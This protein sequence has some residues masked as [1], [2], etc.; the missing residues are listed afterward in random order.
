MEMKKR[1]CC[2]LR[3]SKYHQYLEK[4]TKVNLCSFISQR[5]KKGEQCN[6]CV[7]S[8]SERDHGKSQMGEGKRKDRRVVLTGPSLIMTTKRQM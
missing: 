1:Y 2:I 8:E 5:G 3:V 6:N 4:E 7:N